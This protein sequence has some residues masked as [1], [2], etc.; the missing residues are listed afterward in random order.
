MDYLTALRDLPLTQTDVINIITHM[1]TVGIILATVVFLDRYRVQMD[2]A[3]KLNDW[4]RDA[5]QERDSKEHSVLS[6]N[7]SALKLMSAE[8]TRKL[9]LEGKLDP[10]D[11]VIFLS[12]RCRDFA[13]DKRGVNAIAEEFYDEVCCTNITGM[14]SILYKCVLLTIFAQFLK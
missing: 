8:E 2:R 11:N 7:G 10:K 1:I 12:K 3:G 4:I 14:V 13:A 6:Q 5:R 9:I